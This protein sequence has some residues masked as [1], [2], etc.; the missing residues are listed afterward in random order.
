MVYLDGTFQNCEVDEWRGV[1]LSCRRHATMSLLLLL[2]TLDGRQVDASDHAT[3]L[4]NI[5]E[6]EYTCGYCGGS[7]KSAHQNGVDVT[8][9]GD[10]SDTSARTWGAWSGTGKREVWGGASGGQI[11]DEA[12]ARVLT[13]ERMQA[14]ADVTIVTEEW[15]RFHTSF[16][17]TINQNRQELLS[18]TCGLIS[19]T[20]W[21]ILMQRRRYH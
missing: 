3:I 11:W 21:H 15:L 1:N 7:H 19:L 4:G 16:H 12:G 2:V 14:L 18:E 9:G 8:D 10:D 20:S 17:S 5:S 13:G 6:G